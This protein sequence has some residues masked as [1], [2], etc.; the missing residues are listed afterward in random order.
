MKLTNLEI[1]QIKAAYKRAFELEN[2]AQCAE[3][4]LSNLITRVTGID[5]F[6]DL[7]S[8]D[9]FGFTPASNNDTHIYIPDLIKLAEQ[10]KD[11]TEELILSNLS[12]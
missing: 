9:G 12:L 3:Q 1:T 11:I 8:G 10:G 6:V 5:G 7:L 2:K 4:S